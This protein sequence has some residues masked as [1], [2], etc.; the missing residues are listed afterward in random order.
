MW[1]ANQTTDNACATLALFNIIMNAKHIKLGERLQA[2][3]EQSSDLTPALK[4]HELCNTTW[5]RSIHNQFARR[6]DLLNAELCLSNAEEEQRKRKPAPSRFHAAKKQRKTKKPL[7]G[8]AYHFVAYVPVD[9]EVYQLDGLEKA[10]V[11]IGKIDPQDAEEWTAVARPYIEARMLQYEDQQLQFNLLA[12]CGSPLSQLRHELATN[13]HSYN[14]LA[15]KLRLRHKQHAD[16]SCN[17][18]DIAIPKP[19]GFLTFDDRTIE[20]YGLYY[21][22]MNME[23][24][25]PNPADLLSWHGA[26]IGSRSVGDVRDC[27]E[28]LF[29]EQAHLRATYKTEAMIVEEETER[30]INRKNDYTQHIHEYIEMLAENGAVAELVKEV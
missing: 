25:D 24:G 9:G 8:A 19:D 10:P 29:S 3:K 11:S 14:Y 21:S 6:L 27:L 30:A 4:G 26:G 22:D 28:Q 13:I 23:F 16:A 17:G 15:A 12:V 2:F 1:F 7:S 5:I 18:A 20:I